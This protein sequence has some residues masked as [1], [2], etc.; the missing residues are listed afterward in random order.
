[1]DPNQRSYLY[2]NKNGQKTCYTS[3][4]MTFSRER[5]SGLN[6][7]LSKKISRLEK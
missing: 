6:Q 2:K 3:R 7:S 5:T 1:M 4:T